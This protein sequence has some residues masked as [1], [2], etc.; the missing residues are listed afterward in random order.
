MS[1]IPQEY[2]QGSYSISLAFDFCQE[3]LAAFTVS[4]FRG[5]EQWVGLQCWYFVMMSDAS[6]WHSKSFG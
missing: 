4:L 2:T 1:L 6:K 3:R 5:I